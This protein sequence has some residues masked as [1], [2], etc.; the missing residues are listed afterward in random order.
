MTESKGAGTVTG[1]ENRYGS[2]EQELSGI[3]GAVEH[4]NGGDTQ[5][6]LGEIT[7]G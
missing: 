2:K 1:G 7:T 6:N 5:E 3:Q 4:R